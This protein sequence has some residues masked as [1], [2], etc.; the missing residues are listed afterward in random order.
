LRN[1]NQIGGV[2]VNSSV[3]APDDPVLAV[4]DKPITVWLVTGAV[5]LIAG[6]LLLLRVALGCGDG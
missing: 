1:S 2:Y 4:G 6:T 3:G 5:L